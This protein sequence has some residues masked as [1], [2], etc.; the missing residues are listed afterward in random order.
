MTLSPDTLGMI[1]TLFT[2]MASGIGGVAALLAHHMKRIDARFDTVDA[3]L[4]R[5]ES[6]LVDVKITIARLEGPQR[7]FQQL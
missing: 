3:R 2:F 1:I 6:E 5:V 7:R 4:T